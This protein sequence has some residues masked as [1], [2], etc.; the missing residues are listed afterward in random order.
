MPQAAAAGQS[1]A[2]HHEVDV[3]VVLQLSS[4]RMQHTEEARRI[5]AN[6]PRVGRQSLDRRRGGGEQSAIADSLMGAQKR[7]QRFRHGEGQHEV[8]PRKE[9][10]QL[11]FQPLAA[12]VILAPRAVAIAAAAMHQMPS[13]A[14]LA[15]VDHRAVH[16]GATAED[17]IDH[18][19]VFGEHRIPEA[20]QVLRSKGAKDLADATHGRDPPSGC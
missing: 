17:G 19:A 6:E 3:R 7:P 2:G 13:V 15:E 18:L 8:M 14:V 20:P 5:A 12:L 4:P 1:P 10:L 9:P 11:F 16:V